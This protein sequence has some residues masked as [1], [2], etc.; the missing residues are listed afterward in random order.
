MLI[1]YYNADDKYVK[2]LSNAVV[3]LI[4]PQ[5][6]NVNQIYVYVA[7]YLLVYSKGWEKLRLN[8]IS[9]RQTINHEKMQQIWENRLEVIFYVGLN[10][11]IT[12]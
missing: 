1:W 11:G 2:K 9:V 3:P 7:Y 5:V 8:G 4:K 10:S 6:T 12:F